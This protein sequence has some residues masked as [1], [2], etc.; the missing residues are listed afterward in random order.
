M[1]LTGTGEAGNLMLPDECG[2]LERK[3]FRVAVSRLAK[4]ELER[5]IAWDGQLDLCTGG[6]STGDFY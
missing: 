5:N 6:C 1:K 2:E 4:S 3:R